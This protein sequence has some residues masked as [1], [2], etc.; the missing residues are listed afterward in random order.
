MTGR[1][2]RSEAAAEYLPYIDL[3]EGEDVQAVLAN[4]REEALVL[5]C[6]I[7][8]EKSLYRYASDKWSV[9][10]VLNHITDTER[11]DAFRAFW[12]ARGFSAP[13]PSYDQDMAA[14]GARA[15]GVAWAAHVE[16]FH[17]VRLSTLSLFAHMPAEGWRRTG[18]ASANR[19][20]VR[21]LAYLIA[22]H[23][24]HHLRVLRERCL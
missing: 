15:D 3:V 24:A 7:S 22:G 11:N 21:A 6:G 13:L 16:E 14:A 12:F 8:E 4:Q 17:R 10:Q 1:P 20:T 23:A 19:F 5:F 18:I 2:E 9:R